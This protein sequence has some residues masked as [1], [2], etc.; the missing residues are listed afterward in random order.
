[1][2][3][4]RPI[5]CATHQRQHCD[6]VIGRIEQPIQGRA[7]VT[8]PL[9]I[10]TFVNG[11]FKHNQLCRISGQVITA[12]CRIQL[13]VVPAVYAGLEEP[14]SELCKAGTLSKQFEELTTCNP[15]GTDSPKLRTTSARSGWMYSDKS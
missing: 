4:S 3:S 9:A 8:H 10:S 15:G 2:C 12:F 14:G 11:A 6:R 5:A 7:A 13:Q 1:M